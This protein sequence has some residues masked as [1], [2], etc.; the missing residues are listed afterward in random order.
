MPNKSSVELRELLQAEFD[1]RVEKNP[2]YSMR[3]FA[4]TL[5]ISS[6]RLSKILRGKQGLSLAWAEKI[7]DRLQF[8]KDK[9]LHFCDL[10][11]AAHSRVPMRRRLAEARVSVHRSQRETFLSAD[12]FQAV[13][14]WYHGAIRE[15]VMV[16]GFKSDSV[17][18]SNR[19]G[20]EAHLIEAAIERLIRLGLL[21]RDKSGVLTTDEGI[22]ITKAD[23]I[24]SEAGRRFHSQMLEKA[25]DALRSQ[26]VLERYISSALIPFDTSDLPRASEVLQGF[27]KSFSGNFDD[28]KKKEAVYCLGLQLFRVDKQNGMST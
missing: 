2:L 22:T 28:S 11:E 9:K 26:P 17:W 1:R 16:Q 5:E 6:S 24:P 20:V 3:A 19:L 4:R 12:V 8:P 27:R 25:A 14:E 18:I 21:V 10:A 7:A 23:G 15:L 13:S